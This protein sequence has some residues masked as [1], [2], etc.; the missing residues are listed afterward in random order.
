VVE[1]ALAAGASPA[2]RGEVLHL[3]SGVGVTPAEFFGHYARMTGRRL[4]VLP[5]PLVRAVAAPLGLL[6]D[7]AP[8]SRRTLEYVTHPGTYSIAKA[9]RLLGWA[10]RVGLAE[11][12]ERTES[13]L[14]ATGRLAG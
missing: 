10:P 1:G 7:R 3:S 13:W 6:G 8:L 14:R 12:M 9:A 11:G 5:L 4:P 2:G